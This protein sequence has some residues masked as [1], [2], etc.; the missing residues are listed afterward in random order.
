MGTALTAV[1]LAGAAVSATAVTA[2]AA[3]A[4]GAA[5]AAAC[6]TAGW[7]SALKSADADAHKPLTAIRTGQHDC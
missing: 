3:S 5:P 7:G 6:D 1:V 2:T 4:T